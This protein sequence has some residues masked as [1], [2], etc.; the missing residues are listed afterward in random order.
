MTPEE[1]KEKARWTRIKRVYGI[2]KEQY[3]ELDNGHCP[4]CLRTWS[5]SVVPCVDHDH[6]DSLVRGIVCRY[7]NH[8][9]IGRHRDAELVHRIAKYLEGPFI[10]KMP[11]KKPKKRRKTK[12]ERSRVGSRSKKQ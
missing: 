2:T 5:D 9:R 4:I 1:K 3:E 10:L 7:C 8:R 6:V 12:S 11:P